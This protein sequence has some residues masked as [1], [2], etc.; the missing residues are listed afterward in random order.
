MSGPPVPPPD[1]PTLTAYRGPAS[2]GGY[3]SGSGGVPP[4]QGQALLRL[5]YEVDKTLDSIAQ[6][7]PG[8]AEEIAEIKSMLKDVMT[9]VAQERAGRESG[10]QTTSDLA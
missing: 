10:G 1:A 6:G 7:A 4:Y 8:C 3:S 2:N 9:N 5:F